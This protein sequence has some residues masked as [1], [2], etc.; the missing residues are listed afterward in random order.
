MTDYFRLK[1]KDIEITKDVYTRFLSGYG[2][3]RSLSREEIL[4]LP[5]WVAIRHFQLQAIIMEIYGL[6]CND[7]SFDDAQLRWLNKWLEITE[8]DSFFN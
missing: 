4:S 8:N 2:K 3:Q 5:Y 1:Q 6:H 7:D